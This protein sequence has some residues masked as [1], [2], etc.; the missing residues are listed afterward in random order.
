LPE[1]RCGCFHSHPDEG[2]AALSSRRPVFLSLAAGDGGM[3]GWIF[4]LPF[5]VG[6]AG[7]A[8]RILYLHRVS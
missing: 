1:G 7:A 3:P 4:F 6:V 8:E 2:A 5:V